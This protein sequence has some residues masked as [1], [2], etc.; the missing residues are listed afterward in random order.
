[1][2]D[3]CYERKE[4]GAK[5]KNIREEIHLVVRAREDI[6]EERIELRCVVAK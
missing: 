4:K 5:T 6:T 3:Q 2:C 1:M